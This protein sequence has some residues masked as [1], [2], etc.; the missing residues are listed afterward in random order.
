[1]DR[2]LKAVLWHCIVYMY[3]YKLY[4]LYIFKQHYKEVYKKHY[5]YIDFCH[6]SVTLLDIEI[7]YKSII[8]N[9]NKIVMFEKMAYKPESQNFLDPGLAKP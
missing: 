2:I 6:Q 5:F 7:L 4:L 3:I 1:M 8:I 9:C